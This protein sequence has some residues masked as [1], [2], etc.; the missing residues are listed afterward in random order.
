MYNANEFEVI[1]DVY[2]YETTLKRSFLSIIYT[3]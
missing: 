3:E 2:L 1:V